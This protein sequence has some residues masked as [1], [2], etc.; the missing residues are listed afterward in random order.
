MVEGAEEDFNAFLKNPI[1]PPLPSDE[2]DLV[3][4]LEPSAT[5]FSKLSCSI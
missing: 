5:V 3:T 1:K 4:E 2:E